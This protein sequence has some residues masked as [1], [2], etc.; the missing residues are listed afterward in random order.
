MTRK[1]IHIALLSVAIS[2]FSCKDMPNQTHG[3]IVLGDSST[4]VTERDPQK[5]QDLV[6]DLKPEIPPAVSGEAALIALA[7][8]RLDGVV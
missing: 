7:K 1:R 3:A 5:L 2:L 6:S 4:I 8:S